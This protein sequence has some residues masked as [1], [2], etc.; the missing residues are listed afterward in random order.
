MS[1][2]DSIDLVLG[3]PG[4]LLPGSPQ[5]TGSDQAPLETTAFTTEII[6]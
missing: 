5:A 4:Y 3:G 2:M 6:E 1:F